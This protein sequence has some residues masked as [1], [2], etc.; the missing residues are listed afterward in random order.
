P[1][2]R[3]AASATASIC[4]GSETSA[5]TAIAFPPIALTVASSCSGWSPTA[6]TRA[7][8][9]ASRVAVAAPMPVA[10]PVTIAVFPATDTGGMLVAHRLRDRRDVA[11]IGAAAA[12]EQLELGQLGP[13]FGVKGAQLGRVAAVERVGLVELR[14]THPGGVRADAADALRPLAVEHG[15]EVL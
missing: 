11:V 2:S 15:R 13:Q 10:A 14:V 6:S 5:C 1:P 12:A 9:S 3:C 4:A 7:P 8:R